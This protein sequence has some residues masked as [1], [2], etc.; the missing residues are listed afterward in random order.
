MEGRFFPQRMQQNGPTL[1]GR[2]FLQRMA[3]PQ[4]GEYGRYITQ[5]LTVEKNA[6]MS[7]LLMK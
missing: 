4:Y 3:N 7:R 2:L 1:A 5:N 6:K